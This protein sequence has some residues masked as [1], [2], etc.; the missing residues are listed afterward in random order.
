MLLGKKRGGRGREAAK[1][2]GLRTGRRVG[3]GTE[4]PEIGGRR[5]RLVVVR[6]VFVS[7]LMVV[8]TGQ[9]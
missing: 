1:V 3:Q 4:R 7:V 8:A 5:T 2:G 6:T 9:G